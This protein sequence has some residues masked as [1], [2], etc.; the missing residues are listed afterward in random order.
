M[1]LMRAASTIEPDAI[2]PLLL[3]LLLTTFVTQKQ[4]QQ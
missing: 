3:S 4:K 2:D 1:V